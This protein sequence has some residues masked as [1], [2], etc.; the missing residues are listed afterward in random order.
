MLIGI[1]FKNKLSEGSPD[2]CG[3]EDRG[4]FYGTDYW[5]FTKLETGEHLDQ[6]VNT[7][8]RVVDDI[9]LTDDQGKIC[10]AGHFLANLVL[11][12]RKGF[13]ERFFGK[14]FGKVFHIIFRSS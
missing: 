7:T 8:Q 3:A 4:R 5:N 14:V 6:L 11:F 10:R 13:S 12:F 9:Y 2:Y 1:V